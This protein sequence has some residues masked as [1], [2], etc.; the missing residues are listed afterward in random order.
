MK[1]L[2]RMW[3]L[4]APTMT[5]D[6]SMLM[7]GHSGDV[8]VPV[9]SFLV[10]HDKGLLLFDSQLDPACYDR[11]PAEVFG[12][13]AAMMRL[14]IKPE[15]RIDRQVEALGYRATDVTHVVLS[16]LHMDHA[17]CARLFPDAQ[18]YCGLGEMRHAY[19]PEPASAGYFR[20][21]DLLPLRNFRW[22]EIDDDFD[23]FADGSLTLLHTPGH[24]PGELSMLVRLPD[25]NVLVTG[26]TAHL[27]AGLDLLLPM[28]FN[29]DTQ[30]SVRSM[31]KLQRVA[32]EN[33]AYIWISHELDHYREMQ[34]PATFPAM[35]SA[36]LCHDRADVPG[37]CLLSPEA[38]RAAVAIADGDG[39]A[40][41]AEYARQEERRELTGDPG[42][43]GAAGHSHDT[44]SSSGQPEEIG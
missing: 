20:L 17:G 3:A 36:S 10:E 26:D 1:A 16:H 23:L 28:P 19:W 4:D 8:T 21:D 29:F 30:Q 39:R 14:E 6:G 13:V 2:N 37:L 22:M 27:A 24:T 35:D 31:R 25:R 11:D 32:R 33:D 18:F 34:A 9:T 42:T 12:P 41:E 40:L 38:G 44:G 43:L 7:V 15:Q 5:L